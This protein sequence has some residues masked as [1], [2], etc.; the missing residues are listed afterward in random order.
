MLSIL[1]NFSIVTSPHSTLTLGTSEW[2]LAGYSEQ[3]TEIE[4]D[5]CA[6]QLRKTNPSWETAQI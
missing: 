1:T 3:G 6:L 5:D 4:K 2:D